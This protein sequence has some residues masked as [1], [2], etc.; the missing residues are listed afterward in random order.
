MLSRKQDDKARVKEVGSDDPF[1]LVK[2]SRKEYNFWTEGD[3][4][5]FEEA[6]NLFGKDWTKVTEHVGTKTRL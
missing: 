4:N 2:K 1:K 3:I 5:K 6:L